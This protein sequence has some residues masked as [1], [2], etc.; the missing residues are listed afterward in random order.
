[1]HSCPN[2]S[3]YVG[4]YFKTNIPL[5]FLPPDKIEL[6]HPWSPWSVYVKIP[7]YSI[8]YIVECEQLS[9]SSWFSS[10]KTTD[11]KCMG[12]IPPW[13]LTPIDLSELIKLEITS[14]KTILKL[15]RRLSNAVDV[16][17]ELL[18]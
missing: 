6:T 17:D 7:S 5:Y 1:M 12:T 8:I 4:K 11:I 16:Y 13:V 3:F 15:D 10:E 2:L 9:K 18:A 14:N